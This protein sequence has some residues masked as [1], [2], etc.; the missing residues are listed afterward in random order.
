MKNYFK[1]NEIRNIITKDEILAGQFGLE[2]EGLRVTK[3]GKLSLKPHP[4]IF[5]DKLENPYI[6]TDFSES[7]I[8]IVTPSFN[9]IK[10]AY[11]FLSF[12]VDI[13]N[14]NIYEDEYIWNQSLPCIIPE[15][16]KIPIAK[17]TEEGNSAYEYRLKLAQKY[18]KKLQLISGIHYNFSFNEKTIEKLHK[19]I[20]NNLTYIEF[21][22]QLY[23][24]VIRNYLQYKWLIIYLTGSSVGCHETFTQKCIKLMNKTTNDGSYYSNTG[25]SYRNASCGYKNQVPLYPSY[26]TIND[27]IEDV[28]KYIDEGLLSESKELYTQVRMKPKDRDNFLKSLQKD[29]IQY[30]EIRTVDI[31]PFDKCG[32]SITDMEFIHLFII[33][34]LLKDESEYVNWQEES[35]INEEKT[36]QDAFNKNL[37]LLKDKK[38]V[39]LKSWALEIINEIELINKT[40]N[41]DKDNIIKVMKE[42]IENPQKT[43]AY[44]LYEIIKN[45]GYINSQISIAKNNKETSMDILI[46]EYITKNEKLKKYYEKALNRK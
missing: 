15:E 20:P 1:I 7:Q 46:G 39:S 11:Q 12:I 34:L 5:G 32:I 17:Y 22:N 8:E 3:D 14:T 29:G 4:E 41:L 9:S 26:E 30:I 23:L 24:K 43:H 37:T 2:K 18:G 33:Y 19:N 16:D 21:K 35:L 27:F 44:Q 36:A 42:R 10:K 13:V 25:V 38:E 45:K 40:L 28:N 31:N 6:T